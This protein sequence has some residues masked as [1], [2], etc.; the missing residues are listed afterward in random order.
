MKKVIGL[1][2]IAGALHG[3]NA[4]TYLII[5]YH[6]DYKFSVHDQVPRLWI[7]ENP[8]DSLKEKISPLFLAGY[9]VGDI[10]SCYESQ[11]VDPFI[12]T[13]QSSYSF[14]ES[15]YTSIE[16]LKDVVSVNRI[17]LQSL[18]IKWK[19]GQRVSIKIYA[20]PIFGKFCSTVFT[21]YR[22]EMTDYSGEIYFPIGEYR[23]D[24]SFW[25]SEIG[26][27]LVNWDFS[28]IEFDKIN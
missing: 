3:V 15:H 22:Q 8:L 27:E 25:G 12:Q 18:K 4:Q 10:E 21:D 6:V 11:A 9:S 13:R 28:R 5:E 1:M 19:S 23:Y 7:L 24:D 16:T 17:L 2:L 20:T 26:K 14:D